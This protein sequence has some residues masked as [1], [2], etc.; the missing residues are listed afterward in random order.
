MQKQ[1][2]WFLTSKYAIYVTWAFEGADSKHGCGCYPD[3][4]LPKTLDEMADAFDVERFATD[5]AE[6]GV[7]YVNFTAYH[8]NMFVAYPSAAAE[9]MLPGHASRRDLV[10]ELADALH[11]KNI[12]LQLYIHATIGD[13]MSEADRER[14]HWHDATDGYKHW[15]DLFNGFFGEMT[16][17]YQSKID[18][19]YLDMIFDKPFLDMIDRPR[20]YATLRAHHPGA[21]IVGNGEANE[22][23]DY[24]SREDAMENH[25]DADARVIFPTQTVVCLSNW[26]W[27]INPDTSESVAKYTPE[28]LFRY[29]VATAGANVRGGGLAIGA[30]PYVTGGFEPGIKETLVALGQLIKPIEKSILNTR[31]S[32]AYITPAGATIETLEGG[33]TA[34]QTVDGGTT[35]LHVLRP[36]LGNRIV[37]PAPLDGRQFS[38]A[39]MMRTG[40]KAELLQ[41]AHGVELVVPDPWDGLDTVIELSSNVPAAIG[42]QWTSLPQNQM[43]AYCENDENGHPASLALDGSAETAWQTAGGKM[44]TIRLD[45]GG[46]RNVGRIRVLPRRDGRDSS[47]LITHICTYS[48]QAKTLDGQFRTLATGEWP[49]TMDEKTVEFPTFETDTLLLRSGYEWLPESYWGHPAVASAAKINVDVIAQ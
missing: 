49:R 25:P 19:Y 40:N 3:G 43:T 11:R 22:A 2:D 48:V 15:N 36:P 12:K 6:M 38:A 46:L 13:S 7:Q 32:S 28:H 42:R 17:R 33:F 39:C 47:R 26:W 45:L 8:A 35:F 29:L 24:G 18:S 10:G 9:A 37:L 5:C 20:L 16:A 1:A 31:P 21:V 30:S 4:S 41:T 23:V 34:T 44:N 14:L 27:A